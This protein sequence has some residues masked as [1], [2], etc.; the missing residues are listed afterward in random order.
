M[1]EV[2]P[3]WDKTAVEIQPVKQLRVWLTEPI[4]LALNPAQMG[5]TSLLQDTQRCRN[6][7]QFVTFLPY[8][9]LKLFPQ[10]LTKCDM[11][12]DLATKPYT[13]NCYDI[14]KWILCFVCYCKF[15][16]YKPNYVALN[17]KWR[18]L[19]SIIFAEILFIGMIF[20]KLLPVLKITLKK[21]NMY[22]YWHLGKIFR[23]FHVFVTFIT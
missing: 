2:S 12:Y 21:T 18:E 23:H 3:F 17:R 22:T 10:I 14:F 16:V 15:Q 20:K 6:A 7:R 4:A 5:R 11:V 19:R 8:I 13:R 9:E 1:V